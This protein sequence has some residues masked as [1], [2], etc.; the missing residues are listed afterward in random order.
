MSKMMYLSAD[1]HEGPLFAAEIHMGF[2]ALAP[3]GHKPGVILYDGTS[4]KDRVM[5]AAG[6]KSVTSLF[7]MQELPHSASRA[8][9][10]YRG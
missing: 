7:L 8:I 4:K 9:S 3:L 10:G 5:A 2:S 6:Y 1:G